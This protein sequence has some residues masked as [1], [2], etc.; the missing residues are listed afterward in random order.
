MQPKSVWEYK[1]TKS[2]WLKQEDDLNT[3]NH[4]AQWQFQIHRRQMD[5][6]QQLEE[7]FRHKDNQ[8]AVVTEMKRGYH[9][10][11]VQHYQRTLQASEN[12]TI[13]NTWDAQRRHKVLLYSNDN[14]QLHASEKSQINY[15]TC[16]T[17]AL[18][19]FPMCAKFGGL[20]EVN[21]ISIWKPIKDFPLPSP[22]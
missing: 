21:R 13:V 11:V 5:Y 14:V 4:Q 6:C 19:N 18:N 22:D 3:T 17:D 10:S 8:H 12:T 7:H 1:E 2:F 9:S 16:I 15:G 20:V